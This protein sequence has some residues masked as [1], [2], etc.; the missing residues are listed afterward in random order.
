MLRNTR[1]IAGLS[2]LAVAALAGAGQVAA[3]SRPATASDGA[4]IRI[5]AGGVTISAPD[6]VDRGEA[7]PVT[8]TGGPAGGRLELWGPITTGNAGARISGM[9]VGA[10]PVTIT[11]PEAAGSYELRY[12]DSA[13]KLLARTDLDVAATPVS[14]SIPDP[15]GAGYATRVDWIGPANPGDMIQIVD[16]ATGQVEAEVPAAGK[17]GVY[18]T[19]TLRAPEV[20]GTYR[21]QYWS[22]ASGVSLESLPVQVA[23]GTAWLRSPTEVNAGARFSV[24]WEGPHDPAQAYQLVDPQSGRVL[25][26]VADAGE[27]GTSVRLTAPRKPGEYRV[28]YVNT[29]TGFVLADLPLDVDPK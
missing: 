12:L 6:T 14:L 26:S 1:L 25:D 2:C 3:Y 19:A 27:D 23:D 10:G 18:N 17:P 29:S 11:A 15:V 28:R 22:G 24:E 8:I 9:S 20:P 13:G 5:A 4:G 7:V 21:I 16:P